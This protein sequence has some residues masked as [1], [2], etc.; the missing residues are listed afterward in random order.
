MPESTFTFR[1][2]SELKEAFSQL[3]QEHNRT[4]AQ[5]LRDFMRQFI[6]DSHNQE[7]WNTWFASKVEAGQNDIAKG[8][9]I[10][11]EEA[12]SRAKSRREEFLKQYSS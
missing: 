9:F 6:R 11:N 4:A 8:N 10:T 1:V 7:S 12:E 3:A 5:L 2:D